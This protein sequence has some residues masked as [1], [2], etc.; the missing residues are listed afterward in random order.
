MARKKKPEDPKIDDTQEIVDAVIVPEDESSIDAPEQEAQT[1][2]ADQP[3]TVTRSPETAAPPLDATDAASVESPDAKPVT[4]DEP[5]GDDSPAVKDS[6]DTLAGADPSETEGGQEASQEQTDDVRPADELPTDDPDA[7]IG[8]PYKDTNKP[9]TPAP[10]TTA[11]PAQQV[12]VRKG[13]FFP[14]LLGGVAAAA[15]GFGAA[16]YVLPEGWPWP[17]AA[18]DALTQDVAAQGARIDDLSATVSAIDVTPIED[19]ITGLG[20]AV[21][22]LSGRLDEITTRLTELEQR[23]VA[24]GD[25]GG[26]TTALAAELRDLQSSVAAQR[27]E[28]DAMLADARNQEQQAQETAQQTLA[29]AALTRIQTALDSGSDFS[30][31]LNDLRD[32]GTDVPGPLSDA[33]DGV[34]TLTALQTE[35][36][37]AARRTLTVSRKAGGEASGLGGFLR[38]QL[39]VRSL[40]PQEGDGPDAVLSRAESAVRDGRLADALS[41][42]GALP[43]EGQAEMSDWAARAETRQNAVAAADELA[44]SLTAN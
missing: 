24:Q 18:D 1:P 21:D 14:L 29:R 32:T 43:P 8:D 5:S 41:E 22:T 15:I 36:P 19:R 37:D 33:A 17:G 39:G 28:L 34:P 35:F 26:D 4:L 40:E 23:P 9:E 44:Q 20:S 11:P 13:G 31:A 27:D 6:D 10:E 3:D 25:G 12:I 42:I 38:T 30:D 2:A 7:L 16:R